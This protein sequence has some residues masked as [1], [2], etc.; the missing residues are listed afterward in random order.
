MRSAVSRLPSAIVSRSFASAALA[1][2]LIGVALGARGGNALERT[3]VVELLLIAAGAALVCA[4]IVAGQ[5][6]RLDGGAAVA[7][8]AALAALTA[9]TV[10]WSIAPDVSYVEAGRTFAYLMTFA[11]AVALARLAPTGA[12]AVARGILLAAVAI[13]AYGL[14][15]RV[16]P[17]S[18]Q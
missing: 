15:T 6:G 11:G 8:F 4:A 18:F 5:R 16:W 3:A 17:A 2:A 12:V 10:G 14:A 7:A 9:L 13:C 1:A